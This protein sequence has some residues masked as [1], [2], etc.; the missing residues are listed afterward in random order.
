MCTVKSFLVMGSTQ[1]SVPRVVMAENGGEMFLF[2]ARM[3]TG[4]D[5]TRLKKKRATNAW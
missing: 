4:E 3:K 2:R 5:N 1:F